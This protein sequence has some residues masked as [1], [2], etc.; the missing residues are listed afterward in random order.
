MTKIKLTGEDK[1]NLK[2]IIDIIYNLPNGFKIIDKIV[3]NVV[4]EINDAPDR[5]RTLF[6][7]EMA[8]RFMGPK[9]EELVDAIS[10]YTDDSKTLWQ[11]GNDIDSNYADCSGLLEVAKRYVN[12]SQNKEKVK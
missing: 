7:L 5:T 8:S 1:Y 6:Y 11:I 10:L 3:N 2:N 9:T 12:M 4:L